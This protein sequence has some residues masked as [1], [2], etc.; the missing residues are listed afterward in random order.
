[1]AIQSIKR[2]KSKARSLSNTAQLDIDDDKLSTTDTRDTKDGP[3]TI[4]GS[5]EEGDRGLDKS[6]WEVKQCRTERAASP[7]APKWGIKWNS[8]GESQLRGLYGKGSKSSLQS[9]RK[10]AQESEKQA[11]ETYSISAV[12]Q[13]NLDLGLSSAD[14]SHEGLG[15]SL[16]SQPPSSV[17]SPCLLS[18]IPQGGALLLR[19]EFVDD[20]LQLYV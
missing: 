7:E 11:L 10:S 2:K 20:K 18:E 3:G 6:G 13:R 4:G 19:Q 14:N 8:E 16:E 1:M 12:W 5:E 9:Q 17:P 15:Q